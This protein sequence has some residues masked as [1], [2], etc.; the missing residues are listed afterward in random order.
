MKRRCDSSW[1]QDDVFGSSAETVGL[2]TDLHIGTNKPSL[3]GILRPQRDS[4]FG[5]NNHLGELRNITLLNELR[6]P[7]TP[8]ELGEPEGFERERG[9]SPAVA[10]VCDA[11]FQLVKIGD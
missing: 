1:A 10:R 2:E 9:R 4:N 6:I 7:E 5:N 3:V 11:S 8:E